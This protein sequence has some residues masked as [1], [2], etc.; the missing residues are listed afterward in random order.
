VTVVAPELG[1]DEPLIEL[2]FPHVCETET[3][4]GVWRVRCTP[5]VWHPV[6]E[7]RIDEGALVVGTR[8]PSATAAAAP[9]A[10]RRIVVP[11]ARPLRFED[12]RVHVRSLDE[13]RCPADGPLRAVDVKLLSVNHEFADSSGDYAR[14]V[15]LEIPGEA[16]LRFGRCD[17]YNLRCRTATNGE[18]DYQFACGK[19]DIACSLRIEDESVRFECSRPTVYSGSVL[20]PCGTRG[21]FREDAFRTMQESKDM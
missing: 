15:F 5:L 19:D 10:T 14:T 8:R 2:E 9:L 11:P 21:R 4:E 16:L 18:R 12:G 20:L 1:L 3:A 13:Y 17:K 7:A 6:F